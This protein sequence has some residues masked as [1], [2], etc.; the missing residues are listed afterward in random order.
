MIQKIDAR[1]KQCPIPLIEAKKAVE[2]PGVQIVEVLV[3]N[4][5]AVQNLLKMTKQKGLTADYQEAHDDYLVRIIVQSQD[6]P[7]DVV[8][9]VENTKE[10][11]HSDTV[12]VLSSDRMGQGDDAL[13]KVLMKG[14]LYALTQQQLPKTILL[15]N[16]GVKLSAEDTDAI[17]DLTLL[18]EQGVEILSCGTCLNHY[19]LT[20]QLAVGEVTNMYTIVEKMNQAG[21]L[22]KP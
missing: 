22:I 14:F 9:P 8:A 5:I 12:V 1:G 11:L 6:K 4:E 7:L 17:S 2:T 3:D 15:Y 18:Q 13:G 19:Q 10:H 21:K 16:S 20:D